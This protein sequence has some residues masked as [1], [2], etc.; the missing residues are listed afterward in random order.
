M[1][2]QSNRLLLDKIEVSE[3]INRYCHAIDTSDWDLLTS[4]FTEDC[5]ADFRSFGSREIMQGRDAWVAA[6]Q[7]T[8]GGLDVTHHS[9]SNHLSE[10]DGDAAKLTAYIQAMHWLQNDLGDPEY[11]IGGYYT[12]DLKRLAE[13]WRIT[14]YSLTVTW[15]RGNRH[16]LRLGR[17]WASVGGD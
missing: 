11:T 12:C 3:V 13:G 16:I 1:T 9:T 14:R 7:E 17:R 6:V 2:D 10:I 8:I 15:Q 5:E 4:C